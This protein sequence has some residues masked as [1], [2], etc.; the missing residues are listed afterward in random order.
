MRGPQSRSGRHEEVK[1]FN[2]PGL[3]LGLVS[4]P[5]RIQSLY[6]LSYPGSPELLHRQHI[7]VHIL[8]DTNKF[9]TGRGDEYIL[10]KL[11]LQL[12]CRNYVLDCSGP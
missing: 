4:R 2:P 11:I 5:A 10:L 6:R 3:E 1:I 12:V 9:E 7:V 8:L